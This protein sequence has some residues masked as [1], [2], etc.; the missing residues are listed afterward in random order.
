MNKIKE[1]LADLGIIIVGSS[2][3]AFIGYAFIFVLPDKIK[4]IAIMDWV[5]AGGVVSIVFGAIAWFTWA[6]QYKT[7]ETYENY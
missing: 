2:F 5:I 1:I 6:L 7:R 4:N 3:V